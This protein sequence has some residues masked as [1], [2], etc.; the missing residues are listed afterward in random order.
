[1]SKDKDRGYETLEELEARLP[2]ATLDL[3]DKMAE[4]IKAKRKKDIRAARAF[5]G[6][7]NR[8]AW[9]RMNRRSKAEAVDAGIG[10]M[11]ALLD[12]G[13]N[14]IASSVIDHKNKWGQTDDIDLLDG[15]PRADP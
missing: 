5:Q 13:H 15:D 12:R 3:A 4:K 11:H 8:D 14:I 9:N 10:K 6:K 7:R 2:Q 1:M